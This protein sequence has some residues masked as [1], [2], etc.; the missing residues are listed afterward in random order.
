MTAP[1]SGTLDFT[2]SNNGVAAGFIK[3]IPSGAFLDVAPKAVAEQVFTIYA[4]RTRCAFDRNETEAIIDFLIEALEEFDAKP[5][6]VGLDVDEL[7]VG[8]AYEVIA[9]SGYHKWPIGTLVTYVGGSGDGSDL[10]TTDLSRREW[11]F[12]LP[13][14]GGRCRAVLN[15]DLAEVDLSA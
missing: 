7:E 11:D 5:A 1:T 12:A 8:K 3:G 6:K 9:D 10:A 14:E 2:A 4:G 15:G 13:E